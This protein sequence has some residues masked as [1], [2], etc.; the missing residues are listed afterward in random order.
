MSDSLHDRAGATF[1]ELCEVPADERARRLAELASSDPAL[2]AEVAALLEGDRAPLARLDAPAVAGLDAAAAAPAEADARGAALPER[3]GPYRIVARLGAGGMGVVYEAEQDEPRRRVALKVVRAGLVGPEYLGRFRREAQV[4]ARLNHPGIAQIYA[5]GTAETAEGQQPYFAMELVRGEPITAWAG[6]RGLDARARVDLVARV[7]DAVHHAHENGVVHRD[8][9]PS[10]VLV[11]AAGR[12]VVLDFGVARTT[13]GDL[14]T[15]TLHTRT[16]ELVGTLATMSP[17]QVRGDSS[18]VDARSDVYAL[19]VLAYRLLAGVLPHEVEATP[20]HEAVRA[21]LEDEP[22]T[23]GALVPALRGDV[24]TIVGKAL[25]KDPAR[26]YP[27]AAEL[28]ADLRRHL[29]DEPIHARPPSRTYQLR[30]LARR[31]RGLVTGLAAV[32]LVLLAGSVVST[33][34]FLRARVEARTSGRVTDFLVELFR[35]S[36]PRQARGEETTVRAALDEGAR[37]IAEELGDEPAVRVRLL[38][39]MGD[40]YVSLGLP[41]DALPLLEEALQLRVQLDGERSLPCAAALLRLGRAR[42]DLGEYAVSEDLLRR[43]LELRER[44]LGRGSH[45]VGEVLASLANTLTL[46]G[47]LDAAEPLLRES[48]AIAG[49]HDPRGRSLAEARNTLASSLRTL[50]KRAESI[51]QHR[52]ALDILLELGDD[53]DTLVAS[54]QNGLGLALREDGRPAEG[55]PLLRDALALSERLWGEESEMVATVANNLALVLQDQGDFAGAEEHLRRCLAIDRALLGEDHPFLATDL[56]NLAILLH[57]MDRLEEAEPLYRE[58]LRLRRER[59]GARHPSVIQSLG[60]VGVLLQARGDL[61]GAEASMREALAL[62]L[63]VHGDAHPQ[64]EHARVNLAALLRARGELAESER[65]LRGVL[66]A[67]HARDDEPHARLAEATHQ[68]ADTLVAA[69][70]LAGAEAAFRE[71]LRHR[72]AAGIEDHPRGGD[73]LAGLAGL[74]ARTD[75]PEEARALRERALEVYEGTMAPDSPRLVRLRAT[76]G[77]TP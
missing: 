36:D 40:V 3:I 54:V 27:T 25:E 35:R 42:R 75:R 10:N 34:L 52:A 2:H 29:R 48:V 5:A 37:R 49:R 51:E 20:L 22:S 77:S 12:P 72:E 30:R 44:A 28:A 58:A 15:A 9:K 32:F 43:A 73:C 24:E 31:N 33:T 65:L 62:S 76:L 17:E 41:R 68:L 61:E 55:E 21:I 23:L 13:G 46:A 57:D 18:R 53:E 1:L 4:L 60:N 66:T 7:C 14:A 59:L 11:D 38:E 67:L 26:R 47:E 64:T 56:D 63:E 45:E 8:L 16:G 50:G 70:D 39:A 71:A 6:A 19:G 69:D 74:L